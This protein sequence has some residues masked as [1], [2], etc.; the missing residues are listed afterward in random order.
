MKKTA[1]RFVILV[2]TCLGTDSLAQVP[3]ENVW[4]E[5]QSV[6]KLRDNCRRDAFKRFPDYTAEANANRERSERQCLEA[7]NLPY[8]APRTKNNDN[9]SPQL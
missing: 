9:G 4:K 1:I 2:A 3:G 7:N 6:W 8:T 5:S